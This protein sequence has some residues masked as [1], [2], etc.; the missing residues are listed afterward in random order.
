MMAAVTGR[1][2]EQLAG[3]PHLSD[4]ALFWTLFGVM[5]AA[6][7]LTNRP[8]DTDAYSSQAQNP[9][10]IPRITASR[11]GV[12]VLWVAA[13]LVLASVVLG[14]TLVRDTNYALA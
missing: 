12:P 5:A 1:S 10:D 2:V 14:F 4:E 11:I 13:A 3:I 7:I 9:S 8:P 6:P